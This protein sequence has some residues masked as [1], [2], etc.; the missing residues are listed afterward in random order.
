MVTSE[1]FKKNK[2]ERS[3]TKSMHLK[4]ELNLSSE[5]K[6]PKLDMKMKC[7]MY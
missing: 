6:P 1:T 5:M 4:V 3:K 2:P 7:D